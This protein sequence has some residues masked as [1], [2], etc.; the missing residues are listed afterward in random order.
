MNGVRVDWRN[1]AA[2][3]VALL[4]PLVIFIF[5]LFYFT[6]HKKHTSQN[7]RTRVR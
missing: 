1:L 2:S 3:S 6:R 7:D 5:I 4:L